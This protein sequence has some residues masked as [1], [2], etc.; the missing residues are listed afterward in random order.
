MSAGP[1]SGGSLPQG[2]VGF[3]A[4][5]PH[6]YMHSGF[7]R[8]RPNGQVLMATQAL[9]ERVAACEAELAKARADHAAALARLQQHLVDAEARERQVRGRARSGAREAAAAGDRTPLQAAALAIATQ[10]TLSPDPVPSQLEAQAAAC[11]MACFMTGCMPAWRLHTRV[12]WLPCRAA[13]ARWQHDGGAQRGGRR[14]G[15]PVRG[16][17]GPGGREVSTCL[18]SGV[19]GDASRPRP[20]HTQCGRASW[21]ATVGMGDAS[22]VCSLRGYMG[23]L[24][25]WSESDPAHEQGRSRRSACPLMHAAMQVPAAA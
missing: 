17:P 7:A 21:H 8:P 12:A 19:S 15:G 24:R 18:G 25:T 10:L 11:F 14:A 23:C 4:Q 6:A 22:E 2:S 3:A 1:F 5:H 9:K 20:T 13:A 16:P